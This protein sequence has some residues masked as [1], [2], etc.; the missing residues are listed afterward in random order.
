[1]TK[2]IIN[3]INGKMGQTLLAIA[4]DTQG[5]EVVA[6][7]DKAKS[8]FSTPFPIFSD[9]TDCN[10][11]ADVVVDFSRPAALRSVLSFAHEA[12]AA[13]VLA[14]TGYSDKDM[15]YIAAQSAKTPI[16]I[17]ANMSPGVNLQIDLVK[18]AA[19]FF[20]DAYDI[21]IIEK[22]HNRK[23]DAPS[24]TALALA[25]ALNEPF[26]DKKEY[27]YGR[28]SKDQRRMNREIGIHAIRGGNIVGEH[29]VLFIGQDEVIEVTHIAQS[30][31]IFAQGALR[32]AT[33]VSGKPPKLYTMKDII[34][35]KHEITTIYREDGQAL[36]TLAQLPHSAGVIAGVFSAVAE[37][38][39]SVDMISQT[40]PVQG[41]MELTFSLPKK[42]LKAAQEA[43]KPVLAGCEK[44]AMLVMSDMVKLTMESAGMERRYGVAA[45]AFSALSSNGIEIAAVTT[46]ETKI[47]L[48]V[49]KG[50][51][52]KAIAAIK[53]AFRIS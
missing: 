31:R 42:D 19:S 47:S 30:R 28:H 26:I 21:E 9:I 27:I 5:M 24:G 12:G 7:A 40:C 8:V 1:M 41:F 16:F 37:K 17:S 10:V 29:Q 23:V 39:I 14:T 34:S 32:A 4:A 38:N 20:G 11:K 49:H 44:A 15:E 6:G 2:I 53:G 33:W 50:D 52:E 3:G 48:C 36:L 25:A 43:L 18:K 13:V 22:H 46:S 51:D 45:R 35:E